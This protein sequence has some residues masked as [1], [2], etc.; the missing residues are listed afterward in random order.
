MQVGSEGIE[1]AWAGGV[2]GR[3]V[4]DRFLPI[5]RRII[6]PE[7]VAYLV[8]VTENKPKEIANMLSEWNLKGEIVLRRQAVNEGLMIMRIQHK[9]S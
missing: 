2:D 3:V 9:E 8:L 1:A 6:S 4:I 5:L 7:G